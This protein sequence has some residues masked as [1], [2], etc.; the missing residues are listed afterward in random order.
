AGPDCVRRVP[1]TYLPGETRL[2]TL[3]KH[4]RLIA[5]TCVMETVSA[6]FDPEPTST[7]KR[8][9]GTRC[10]ECMDDG[11]RGAGAA[12]DPRCG[13]LLRRNDPNHLGDQHDDDGLLRDGRRWARLGP[14][15][16]RTELR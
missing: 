1:P 13:V 7:D 11:R 10:S 9:H 3:R 6:R 2:V 14:L 8:R 5:V 15:R 12:H 4:Y 16:V